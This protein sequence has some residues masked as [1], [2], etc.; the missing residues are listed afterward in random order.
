MPNSGKGGPSPASRWQPSATATTASPASRWK[1]TQFPRRYFVWHRLPVA[2]DFAAKER[3]VTRA[4]A[5][6]AARAQQR[7]R[8]A[9][10]RAAKAHLAKARAASAL[11]AVAAAKAQAAKARAASAPAAVTPAAPA[12]TTSHGNRPHARHLQSS[13]MEEVAR[14]KRA[15]PGSLA[16]SQALDKRKS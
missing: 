3:R 4:L 16:L 1:P 10:A 5:A 15:A 14:G 9:R 8:A 13:Q 6:L 2:M 11:A 7:A 12:T